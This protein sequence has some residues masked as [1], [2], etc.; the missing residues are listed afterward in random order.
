MMR[1]NLPEY[2]SYPSELANRLRE[3]LRTSALLVKSCQVIVGGILP[4]AEGVLVNLATG[5]ESNARPFVI[6]LILVG[7][8]HAALLIMLL[9]LETPLP[10][11]LVQFDEQA[12]NI[13]H[14]G[15]EVTTYKSYST[16]FI[17]AITATLYS[18][19]QIEDMT[20]SPDG[21][22]SKVL[23]RILF[24]WI[25]QRTNIFWFR[26]GDALYNFVVYVELEPNLLTVVYRSH[27]NRLVPTNRSWRPGDGH[28]GSC[29]LQ[30]ETIFLLIPEGGSLPDTLRT[31]QPRPEDKD[32]YISMMATPIMLEE[33]AKGV[34]VI[35]SS[36]PN[37]FV[38]ELHA[39]IIDVMGM[40]LAQSLRYCW[41]EQRDENKN[42]KQH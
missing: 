13:Q 31:S 4:I 36:K 39:P 5:T 40:L 41:K 30:E 25:E 29:F 3:Q 22:L 26:D 24:P 20:R 6:T 19:I 14:A 12:T 38:K 17:E 35:T 28:V 18:M 34:L 27:D 8:I 7:V 33:K 10:Q 23:E 32:Y 15:A 37:Q 21:D 1:F 9:L 42:S 16:T 2:K 11:F